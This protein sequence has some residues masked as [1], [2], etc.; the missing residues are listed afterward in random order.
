MSRPTLDDWIE[1]KINSSFHERED[2]ERWQL[3]RLNRTLAHAVKNSSF[4]RSRY[5]GIPLDR[6]SDL[7]KLPFTT[8]QELKEDPY[9]MVCV[10]PNE[11][12]R[13]VT[14]KTSGS[15]GESKRVFFTEDDIELCT[16]YFHYGMRNLVDETDIV[17]IL[18][19]FRTPGS[20]GDQ[21]IR[22]LWRL[23]A[24]TVA[25]FGLPEEEIASLISFKKITSLAGMPE[26]IAGLARRFPKL[27]SVRSVLLSA[28]FVSDE[29]RQTIRSNWN[30]EVFEHYGMTE[31]GLGCAVSCEHQSG[32][33]VREADMILEIIDPETGVVLPDGSWG[34]IVFT[35][36]TRVGMPFIRYRTGDIS[37]WKTETCS[38]GTKLKLLDYIQDR[39]ISK[40]RANL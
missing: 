33:H 8:P 5:Q 18:F 29:V 37:R 4:Y 11:I 10:H 38:C 34:E 16:D 26:Q 22:G 36:L 39:Q 6:L 32:Y 21:L 24:E 9:R 1:I 35:S 40:G 15:T 2:L 13:I 31:M 27:T 3:D 17:G 30:A 28:D 23:G 19:P 12:S 14:L 7:G 20:V 25:L